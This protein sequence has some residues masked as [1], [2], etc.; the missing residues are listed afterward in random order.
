MRVVETDNE[1]SEG[2]Q[3]VGRTEDEMESE[4]GNAEMDEETVW[5]KVFG[6][7]TEDDGTDMR[8][9]E[10]WEKVFGSD[11]ND[12]A[13]SGA[14]PGEI[15]EGDA[16]RPDVRP[17]VRGIAQP[18]EMTRKQRET[19]WLEGHVNYHPGC[20]YCV[21]ARGL[22]NRHT[23]GKKD[24][25]EFLEGEDEVPTVS[26]DLCFLSQLGQE[27]SLT[28]LVCKEHRK[29]CFMS[30]V[31]PGKSTVAEEYSDDIVRRVVEFLDFLGYPRVAFKTDNEKSMTAL[32]E[33]VKA[34]RQ[35]ET[36]LS[37]SKNRDS[38]SNG[39]VERAIQQV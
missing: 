27:K 14:N 28:V 37:N 29:K 3:M 8:G 38:Q 1:S 21:R 25:A 20:E 4:P 17:R 5:E 11:A 31:C 18:M 39:M 36:F 30:T 19:H 12:G 35:G 23:S 6:E 9:E 22:A 16:G 24:E 2:E 26:A 13:G 7:N 15:Q 34:M 10:V 33:R 32:Q